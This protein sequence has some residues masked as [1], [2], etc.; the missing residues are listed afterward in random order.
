MLEQ[1]KTKEFHVGVLWLL[2][3]VTNCRYLNEGQ[4][5]PQI[6]VFPLLITG[7]ALVVGACVARGAQ[8]RGLWLAALFVMMSGVS[9]FIVALVHLHHLLP[10]TLFSLNGLLFLSL[11]HELWDVLQERELQVVGG[12]GNVHT[13]V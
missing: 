10:C 7:V 12:G 11:A 3:F 8:W 13:T 1:T 4:Q 9:C 2:L 6:A 5:D